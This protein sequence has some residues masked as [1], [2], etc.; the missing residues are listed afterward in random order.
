MPAGMTGV[1]DAV[2]D[3]EARKNSGGSGSGRLWFRL[4]DGDSA[5]VRFLEQGDDVSW[6]W[7]HEVPI[8][9]REYGRP[10][11]C[12]DQDESGQ[13]IGEPC[14][15]CE[16]D[17]KRKFQGW[18]NVIW[19]DAPVFKKNAEGRLEKDGNKRPIVVGY[20]DQVACWQSGIL[21]FEELSG[22][23]VTYKG[24]TSRD[25]RITR[26]GTGLNT[27]Y[28]IEPADPDGGSQPL[29]EKDKQLA[30]G[31]YD[32]KED[33]VPAPYATWGQTPKSEEDAKKGD[34]KPADTSPFMNRA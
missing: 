13:R 3:I 20:D 1:R 25:F 14:P 27:K 24:L 2:K 12:R 31:K 18:I 19:R 11:A 21:V 32:F 7:C 26:R 15:G 28:S 4:G 22:K 6:A 9:G 33:V 8:E 17:Q 16:K 29:S 34:F 23:D 5:V 10:V 30:A